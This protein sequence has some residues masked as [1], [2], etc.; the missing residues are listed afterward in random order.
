[1]PAFH[2]QSSQCAVRHCCWLMTGRTKTKHFT[3]LLD[4][5]TVRYPTNTVGD[6][7]V[8]KLVSWF[9]PASLCLTTSVWQRT[10]ADRDTKSLW[11]FSRFCFNEEGCRSYQTPDTERSFQQPCVHRVS[12]FGK[13]WREISVWLIIHFKYFYSLVPVIFFCIMHWTHIKT[14]PPSVPAGKRRSGVCTSWLR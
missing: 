4:T 6:N 1:M 11:F 13:I 9:T 2:T 8:V 10:T 5:W 7:G 12:L 14:G 3:A